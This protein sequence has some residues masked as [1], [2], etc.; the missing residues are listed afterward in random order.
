MKHFFVI[1]FLSLVCS[2]STAYAQG[3]NLRL[4]QQYSTNGE[5]L[6]ALDIYQKLY[7]SD[8]EGYYPFYFKCLLTLKK[9]DDAENVSKKMMR[10]HPEDHLYTIM[11]GSIYTQ[12]GSVE[13]ANELYDDLVKNLP[14]D[15]GEIAMLAA[16]F[17]QN[18][19]IDYAIKIFLINSIDIYLFHLI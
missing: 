6:K 18:S 2:Y 14:A 8:N 15:Q 1:I 11:L 7:K 13:K 3:D 9:Y 10:K 17:Y 16:Q 4:A 5:P 12:Q 19:N